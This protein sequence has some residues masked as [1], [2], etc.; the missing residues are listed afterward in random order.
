MHQRRI[1]FGPI[2]IKFL[3]FKMENSELIR[4][5]WNEIASSKNLSLN[6]IAIFQNIFQFFLRFVNLPEN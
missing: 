5:K 4:L 6:H 2:I 3:F 1:N